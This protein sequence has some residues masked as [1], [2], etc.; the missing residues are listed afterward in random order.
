MHM[1]HTFLFDAGTWSGEGHM[2]DR[3]GHRFAVTGQSRIEHLP[4][5]WLRHSNMAVA[6][7]PPVNFES[8]Y[9]IVPF[10]QG[11]DATTCRNYNSALGE[12]TGTI[13]VV[14]DSLM[15][16]LRAEDLNHWSMEC[17]VQLS[18]TRY[19]S[20]GVYFANGQ[21]VSSWAVELNRVQ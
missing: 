5:E 16:V 8:E 19:L 3:E 17:L 20:R 12:F 4:E 15:A 9:K 7:E 10:T 2:T 6:G 14:G 13:A 1:R 21:L 11:Q 18:A